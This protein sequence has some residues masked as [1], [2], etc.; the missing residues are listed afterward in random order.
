[1]S[2]EQAP[3]AEDPPKDNIPTL[4]GADKA[5]AFMLALPK[6]HVQ[7]IFTELD[8]MEVMELSQAMANLGKVRAENIENLFIE[9]VE[10]SGSSAT[11]VGTL[12]STES[13]LG[14][15]FDKNKVSNI[16]EEIR[17]PAGR[18]MWDKLNNVDEASLSDYLKNEHPQTIAVVLSKIKPDH[19][20]KIFTMFPDDLSLEIMSRTIE[21][22]TVGREV[23]NNIEQTL[24]SEFIANFSRGDKKDPHARL[25]EVFNFFDRP[26]EGRFMD[27]LEGVNPEAAERVRALMFTFNDL[28]K[29]NSPGMQTLMRIVDKSK[30]ALAL[31]GS[32]EEIKELFF[33]NMSERA[34]KLLKEDMEGLGMVRLRDVDEAQMVVVTQTKKLIDDGEIEIAQGDDDGQLIE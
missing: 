20:A 5:A 32:N 26:T 3:Q 21:M 34:A 15:I 9:F 4:K 18:T 2:A 31:K 7:K 8:E 13:L 30:L 17:G 1:M 25:A 11:L 12:S 27:A 10:R 14:K 19:A 22:D 29:M 23:L 33:S 6:D 16:M 24:K 28:M